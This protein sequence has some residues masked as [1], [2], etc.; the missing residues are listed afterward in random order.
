MFLRIGDGED[1][2]GFILERHHCKEHDRL[3][4]RNLHHI[5]GRVPRCVAWKSRLAGRCLE[6]DASAPLGIQATRLGAVSTCLGWA[7]DLAIILADAWASP[8]I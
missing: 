8:G 3:R 4:Q 6:L 7:V 1:E 2:R 5:V